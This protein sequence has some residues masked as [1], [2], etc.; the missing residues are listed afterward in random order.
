MQA[1][2][3]PPHVEA[4]LALVNVSLMALVLRWSVVLSAV[5]GTSR[6]PHIKSEERRWRESPLPLEKRRERESS[7]TILGIG[8]KSVY[9][10]SYGCAARQGPVVCSFALKHAHAH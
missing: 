3:G 9:L 6:W 5:R 2:K 8:K 1:K 10:D 7:G 4:A